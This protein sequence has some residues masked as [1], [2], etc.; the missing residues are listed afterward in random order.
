[1]GRADAVFLDEGEDVLVVGVREDERAS[2]HEALACLLL[3]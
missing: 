2:E 1:V 3:G